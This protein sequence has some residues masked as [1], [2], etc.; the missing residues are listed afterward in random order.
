MKL[1]NVFARVILEN[2]LTNAAR[3]APGA[4]IYFVRAA[5]FVLAVV[6]AVT[7]VVDGYRELNTGVRSQ[8]ATAQRWEAERQ[9]DRINQ[10]STIEGRSHEQHTHY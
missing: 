6:F 8:T 7:I 9:A 10:Q 5:A 4:L 2:A 1:K 3:R